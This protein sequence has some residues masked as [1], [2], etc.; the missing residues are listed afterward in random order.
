[1][2]KHPA[3]CGV[4]LLHNKRWLLPLLVA[5]SVSTALAFILRA[6]FDSSCD[7]HHFES[8]K[9]QFHQATGTGAAAPSPL[10]FMKSK[11]VL[12]VS[13]ELS[14]SGNSLFALALTPHFGIRPDFTSEH[15]KL[16]IFI[17]ENRSVF[18]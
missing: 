11:N 13:H 7:R 2:A 5:L 18:M 17:V 10:R 3:G 1:M 8:P 16:C 4:A 14:L 12:L 15:F 9:T 6:A